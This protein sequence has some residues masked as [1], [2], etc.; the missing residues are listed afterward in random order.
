MTSA[1]AT[2]TAEITTGTSRCVGRAAAQPPA[3]GEKSDDHV[4]A[5]A[6]QADTLRARA[7][8]DREKVD[9]AEDRREQ[10]RDDPCRDHVE[11]RQRRSRSPIR[12]PEHECKSCSTFDE[13]RS[14]G[15]GSNTAPPLVLL[16][17]ADARK[18]D[19]IHARTRCDYHACEH[20]EN[21]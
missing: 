2:A 19:R 15:A 21:A 9:E 1:I 14:R 6:Q 7:G 8:R 18:V 12:W 16:E 17:H 11:R 13:A 10:P 5:S 20:A 4:A 3:Q